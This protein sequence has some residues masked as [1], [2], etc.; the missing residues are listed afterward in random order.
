MTVRKLI[1]LVRVYPDWDVDV[2]VADS[3]PAKGTPLRDIEDVTADER[4]GNLILL[5]K[6]TACKKD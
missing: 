2:L 4:N 5:L 1:D 6:G 3:D